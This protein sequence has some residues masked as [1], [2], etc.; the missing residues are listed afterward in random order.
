MDKFLSCD[1]GTTSFRLRLIGAEN[2][3]IIEEENTKQGIAETF[4]SW[5]QSRKDEKSRTA[6]YL[7]II[8]NRIK[9]IEEKC[10]SSLDD[11][12]LIISG[13]ASSTIGMSELP[14]KN[15]PFSVSGKDLE[16]SAIQASDTVKHKVIIISGVKT[17]DDVMRGEETKLIGCADVGNSYNDIYVF[18]GTHPKHVEVKN[19]EV[20]AFKTYMTG[21]FFELLSKKSILAVSVKK[22][23]NIEAEN[24]LQSF[25]K[26]VSESVV[27]NLL[28]SSFLVRTN[29]V[30]KRYSLE[31][32]YFYL[33]GLLIG[34]ELKDLIVESRKITIVGSG[35]LSAQYVTALN[36]LGLSEKNAAVKSID[37]DEALIKGQLKTWKSYLV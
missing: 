14:Y 16:I 29:D 11:V 7:D 32:N 13:M 27:S 1:W 10:G 15:L 17:A 24:N 4:Q 3:A 2:L 20:I 34:T 19:D 12:P 21:E 25:L 26:G 31:E 28:H 37:A 23:E 22:D 18:P 30:F 33:S 5:K 36:G 35:G 9:S 6:F 8:L